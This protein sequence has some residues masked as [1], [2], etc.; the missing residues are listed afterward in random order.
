MSV[1]F[2]GIPAGLSSTITDYKAQTAQAA[3]ALDDK[4]KETAKTI[5]EGLGSVKIMLGGKGVT[6][7]ILDDPIVKKYG[8]QLKGRVVDGVKKAANDALE[9]IK[10]KAG[11]LGERLAGESARG[12]AVANPAADA[13]TTFEN[14]LFDATSATEG[15]IADAAQL[16]RTAQIARLAAGAG[17][18]RYA[19][20]ASRIM[21][22]KAAEAAQQTQNFGRGGEGFDDWDTPAPPE[23]AETD[24]FGSNA[25]RPPNQ[26]PELDDEPEFNT[27]GEGSTGGTGAGD[28]SSAPVSSEGAGAGADS[29][30]LVAGGSDAAAAAGAGAGTDAAIG[31]GEAVLAALDAIPFVD[32]FTL[33]AG[34]GLA[35]GAA[36]KKRPPVKAALPPPSKNYTSFQAGYANI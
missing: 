10:A 9:N 2:A 34:A 18:A 30:D 4:K 1:P 25:V 33:A 6:K 21:E 19:A 11:N 8:E 3:A 26:A 36:A 22:Q 20:Q 29:G 13:S 17:R 23:Y 16:E 32:F 14:P 12:E 28:S 5:E 7:K 27:A 24:P 15:T 35:A 31:G